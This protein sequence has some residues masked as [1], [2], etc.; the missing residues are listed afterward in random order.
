LNHTAYNKILGEYPPRYTGHI[1]PG[2]VRSFPISNIKTGVEE[3]KKNKCAEKCW[4]TSAQIWLFVTGVHGSTAGACC[5]G[6]KKIREPGIR[7]NAEMPLKKCEERN[8][9][10]KCLGGRVSQFRKE[11]KG[12]LWHRPWGASN[13]LWHQ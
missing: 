4:R 6:I 1:L 8:V 12:F 2:K 5:I 7:R 13:A 10:C 3:S 9:R 11:M